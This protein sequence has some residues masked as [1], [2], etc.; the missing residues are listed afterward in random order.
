M[1]RFAANL[2]MMFTEVPFPQRFEAAARAGFTAVEFLFPYEFPAQD[3][4]RWLADNRL[5]NVLF[6]TPPG[7]WNAGDRGCASIPGREA[8]FLAGVDRALEYASVLGTTRLHA[9]AG[10]LPSGADR[11]QHREVY[12]ANIRAA[13]QRAARVGRTLLIEAINPRDIPGYFLNT[14]AEAHAI[15][16]EVA[17]AGLR[18]EIAEPSLKVQMDFYHAQIVEGDLETTFR[19]YFEDIGHVQIAGVPARGEPDRGEV[20]YEHLFGLMDELG[21]AGW[22]GCEYRPRGRT[23][24]G[25]GWLKGWRHGRHIA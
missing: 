11:R 23:E 3:I 2:S 21:Y 16:E 7:D 6:N 20:N 9:L 13:A 22:V 17:E 18:E 8:E 19:R 24:D 25:L 15:R 4:A 12:V 5:E 14:Q 1:P 10:R